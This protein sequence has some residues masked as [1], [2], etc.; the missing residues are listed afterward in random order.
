[1]SNEIILK[2]TVFGGFERK[3]VM[4]YIENE[5]NKVQENDSL[6]V[7]RE[8]YE[9]LELTNAKLLEENKELKAKLEQLQMTQKDRLQTVADTIVLDSVEYADRYL[10]ATKQVAQEITDQSRR[11]VHNAKEEIETLLSGF[12]AVAASLCDMV[13]GIEKKYV[14]TSNYLERLDAQQDTGEKKDVQQEKPEENK[15]D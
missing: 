9:E 3:S 1:M 15:N 14:A 8:L 11:D 4:D 10:E 7:P 12:K 2:K 5:M 6:K 13:E